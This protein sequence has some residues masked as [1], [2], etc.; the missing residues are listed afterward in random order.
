MVQKLFFRIPLSPLLGGGK[1]GK[2]L[3]CRV[4]RK[5]QTAQLFSE[6]Y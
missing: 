4:K 6:L 3:M 5:R 2:G 1:V